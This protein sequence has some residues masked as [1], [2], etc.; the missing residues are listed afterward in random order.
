MPSDLRNSSY[1]TGP[2]R[3]VGLRKFRKSLHSY[4]RC[5]T[6]KGAGT[7]G[8]DH[9]DCPKDHLRVRAHGQS[10]S[11]PIFVHLTDARAA[12][13]RG[14]SPGNVYPRSA[15]ARAR[16]QFRAGHF[17][18]YFSLIAH[19]HMGNRVWFSLPRGNRD[20]GACGPTR[21]SGLSQHSPLG[22]FSP[23][24]GKSTV[25]ARS[26]RRLRQVDFL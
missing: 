13:P 18:A 25:G 22:D 12:I 3:C 14:A 15:H 16:A 21:Y 10:S 2:T 1:N 24:A 5:R 11:F 9:W 7:N 17:F 20:T 4:S 23:E 6:P 26:A 19:V 8:K